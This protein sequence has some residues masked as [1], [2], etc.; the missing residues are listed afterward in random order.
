MES[1]E[2]AI[3]CLE[4]AFGVSVDDWSL[5]ISQKLLDIFEAAV[6]KQ[7]P[8]QSCPI[9]EPAPPSEE[10]AAEGERLKTEGNKQMKV[11]NFKSAI[12]FYGKAIKLNPSNAVYYCNWAAAYSKLA[13]MLGP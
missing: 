3:Q 4:T 12:S 8:L 11:E 10:D 5:A 13:I 2:V 6:A 1:L 7:E 9:A